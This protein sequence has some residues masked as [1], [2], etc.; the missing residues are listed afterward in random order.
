MTAKS[1][2]GLVFLGIAVLFTAYLGV[3]AG[4]P[5][6][7]PPTNTSAFQPSSGAVVLA[8]NL[9]NQMSLA[10]ATSIATFKFQVPAFVPPGTTLSRVI[11]SKDDTIVRLFYNSTNLPDARAFAGSL[12]F[13]A[14]LVIYYELSPY[15]PISSLDGSIAP[16]VVQIQHNGHNA[17]AVQTINQGPIGDRV[18]VCGVTGIVQRASSYSGATLS[19]WSNGLLHIVSADTPTSEILQIGD[20]MC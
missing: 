18:L 20:S 10:Q 7:S 15:N 14:A 6:S 16:I 13:S 17:S 9:G 11:V 19:W 12:P 8:G 4:V 1:K 2:I 5:S 3:L